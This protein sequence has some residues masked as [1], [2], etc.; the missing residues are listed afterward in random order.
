MP[1]VRRLIAK[2]RFGHA[3]PIEVACRQIYAPERQI[4]RHVAQDVRELE[5]DAEID[6]VLSRPGIGAPENP[7]AHEPDGGRDADAVFVQILERVIAPSV[8]VHL[9][10]LDE[11]LERRARQIERGD[12][13]LQGAALVGLRLHAVEAPGHLVA[14]PL[15]FRRA[16]LRRR[17]VHR[18]V[19]RAAEI[20][21]GNDRLAPVG[22][23]HEERVIEAGISSHV[24]I[25]GA[26]PLGLPC[27]LS[28]SPLRRLAPFAWVA[29]RR[30]L[31]S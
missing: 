25:R 9:D 7:Y 17:L 31:P 8:Q 2:I 16:P 13:R 11:R 12:E 4:L 10:A 21:H 29:S 22:G 14:P 3:E 6:R 26:S 15:H 27:T 19:H 20:P 18:V 28:R 24:V 23:Q 30:S 5:R 1:R